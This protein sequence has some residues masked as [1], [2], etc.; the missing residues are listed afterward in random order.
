MSNINAHIPNKNDHIRYKP[1]PPKQQKET[2]KSDT[3]HKY[4]QPTYKNFNQTKLQSTT[5][6]E[7]NNNNNNNNNEGILRN[8]L[9]M[10]NVL[11]VNEDLVEKWTVNLS[12]NNI[13]FGITVEASDMIYFYGQFSGNMNF[14]S[15]E[16]LD[17]GFEN[18]FACSAYSSLCSNTSGMFLSKY[19]YSGCLI[20][21]VKLL[22]FDGVMQ[23][24]PYAQLTVESVYVYASLR[25]SGKVFLNNGNMLN[26]CNGR[27]ILFGLDSNGNVTWTVQLK[28]VVNE[29]L[30]IKTDK[31]G[32]VY[33]VGSFRDKLIRYNPGNPNN[34]AVTL[35]TT[36]MDSNMFMLKFNTSG[37]ILWTV[38][39][40]DNLGKCVLSNNG[41]IRSL[42]NNFMFDSNSVDAQSVAVTQTL[43]I[44]GGDPV[45]IGSYTNYVTFDN[46]SLINPN[47]RANLYVALFN[48]EGCFISLIGPQHAPP[49]LT[50]QQ[51]SGYDASQDFIL[52]ESID[53]DN[54]N[55]YI[56]GTI[57]GR[58]I[59]DD[60]LQPDVTQLSDQNIFVSKLILLTPCD[61]QQSL[62][63]LTNNTI[64]SF[65]KKRYFNT[66]NLFRFEWSRLIIST[67]PE[68]NA[69]YPN[70]S[71]SKS[72][73][74]YIA[75][76]ATGTT[77]LPD[78]DNVEDILNIPG[79]LYLFIASIT[80][81][82]IWKDLTSQ[83]GTLNNSSEHISSFFSGTNDNVVSSGTFI[84]NQTQTN[85]FMILYT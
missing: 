50:T 6:T 29:T 57:R 45:V 54:N 33:V 61:S 73:T 10:K 84:V 46:E 13:N 79:R 75:A 27:D 72:S 82:G 16:D 34:D 77:S 22:D 66:F 24:Q 3:Y 35:A 64:N 21:V 55:I 63:F 53:I 37:N 7:Y 8:E 65:N 36:S 49:T 81:E 15:A 52:G 18:S 1:P 40:D 25:I 47:S 80:S 41:L 17:S 60:I 23:N 14:G 39:S 68:D 58:Y 5:L 42:P 26:S 62:S 31:Q 43:S 56:T 38:C 70:I 2:I 85:P 30:N 74:I 51:L 76:Q 28:N 9:D 48:S 11:D 44:H 83:I 59:F 32:N 69:F 19:D 12:N 71:V 67:L 20:S 78:S 4:I